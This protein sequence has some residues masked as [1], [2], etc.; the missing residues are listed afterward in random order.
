MSLESAVTTAHF[1][2]QTLSAHRGT[3]VNTLL[4]S[5]RVSAFGGRRQSGLSAVPVKLT[6]RVLNQD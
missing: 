2:A 6:V 5:A 1:G 4:P 3:P